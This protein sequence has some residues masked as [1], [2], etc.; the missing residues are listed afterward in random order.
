MANK[1]GEVS[2]TEEAVAGALAVIMG[3]VCENAPADVN[4]L[5]Q[6]QNYAHTHTHTNEH[7]STYSKTSKFRRKQ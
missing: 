2:T 4:S 7:T 3:P 5:T 1:L 6:A